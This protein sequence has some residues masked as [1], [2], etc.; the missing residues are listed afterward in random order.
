MWTDLVSLIGHSLGYWPHESLVCISLQNNRMGATLRLDLPTTP[1]HAHMYARKVG[2]CLSSDKDATAAVLANFT[3]TNRDNNSEALFGTCKNVL[4][5][6][7]AKNH[8][9][10]ESASKEGDDNLIRRILQ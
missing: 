2:G 3:N 9:H 6:T 1:D 5:A 10:S 7:I 4:L 8:L